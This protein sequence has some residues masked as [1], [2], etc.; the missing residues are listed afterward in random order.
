[1]FTGEDVTPNVRTI[2]AI[3][4]RLHDVS[5]DVIEVRG[6]VFLSHR[7]FA[8]I[9]S[10]QE[11]AGG[12]TF[13]NPRNAAAGSVRQKDARVTAGRRLNAFFYGI[14]ACEGFKIGS[15]SELLQ[16]YDRWGFP[17]NP[18]VKVCKGVEEVLE[19]AEEWRARKE[20][21]HYD[22]DG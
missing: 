22:I 11:S 4:L 6:E 1:G 13:A 7:E 18:N 17:T 19:Y 5:A 12:M 15:Q 2:R 9:N 21:L 14:G 16:T 8:R 10:E 20:Q 3:P